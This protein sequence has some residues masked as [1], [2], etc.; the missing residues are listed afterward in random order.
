[1]KHPRASREG[2]IVP[3]QVT[4][5]LLQNAMKDS[6]K[7]RFLIDGF[8]RNPEN[9]AAWEVA[10][11]EAGGGIIFDFALFL[12]CPEEVRKSWPEIQEYIFSPPRFLFGRIAGCIFDSSSDTFRLLLWHE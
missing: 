2:K 5:G 3:A 12:D 11:A 9:L 6:G 7:S 1:M 8:P 10:A 4:V